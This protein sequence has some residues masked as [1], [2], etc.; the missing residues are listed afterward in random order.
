MFILPQGMMDS[1]ADL[2]WLSDPAIHCTDINR[3]GGMNLGKEGFK[4]FFESHKCNQICKALR[5]KMHPSQL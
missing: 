5:C 2:W 1:E 3:F 4:L